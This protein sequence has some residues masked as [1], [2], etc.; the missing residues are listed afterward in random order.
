MKRLTRERVVPTI[1]CKRLLTDLRD[2][3][4]RRS[5]LAEIHQQEKQPCQALLTGIE[6]LVNQ[7]RFNS[8]VASQQMR[9]KHLRKRRSSCS[10]RT[11]AALCSRIITHS[12][13]AL[14]VAM[15]RSWL[16]RHPSPQKSPLPRMATIASFPCFETTVILTLPF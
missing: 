11:M 10:T 15:R 12:V 5:L 1:F 9:D 3:R 13:I 16:A 4:L 14:I 6:Q 7:I 8:D 2:D